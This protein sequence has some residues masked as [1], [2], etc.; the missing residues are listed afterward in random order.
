MIPFSFSH[1]AFNSL[2]VP[3]KS[4][5]ARLKSNALAWSFS[6][7]MASL[8]ISSCLILLFCSS[9][10]SGRESISILSLEAASSIKSMALSGKNRSVMYLLDS[11]TAKIMASSLICTP[12]CNSY[13]SLIPRSM[14]MAS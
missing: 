13:L 2:R 11:S 14:D 6:L 4:A 7:L 10:S 5:M 9:N 12:W 1:L 8:S 3:S